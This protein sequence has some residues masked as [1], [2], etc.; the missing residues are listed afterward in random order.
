MNPVA[1]AATV[2]EAAKEPATAAGTE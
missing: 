2:R 1:E